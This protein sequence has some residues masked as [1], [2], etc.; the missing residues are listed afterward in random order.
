MK[1]HLSKSALRL[2]AETE[3]DEALLRKIE[4]RT[5]KAGH[6]TRR[7]SHQMIPMASPEIWFDEVRKE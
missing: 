3:E 6:V 5:Y 7:T 1:I 4:G 2:T